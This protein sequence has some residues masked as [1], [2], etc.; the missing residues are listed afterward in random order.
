MARVK[1]S[2]LWLAIRSSDCT[3]SQAGQDALVGGLVGGALPVGLAAAKGVVSPFLS[4]IIAQ[5]NPEGYARRQ[6]AQ[7]IA[8]S[9]QTPNDIG[10]ALQ[11]AQLEGQGNFTVADALGN[12][13][14]RMLSSVARAPGEGRTNVVNT[15]ENRQ[16]G[17]G[18]RVAN[19]LSES[20][21]APETAAQTERRLTQA[22]DEA[23][24]E[25]YGA[26]R[27]DANPVD[28]VDTIN[29]VDNIIGSQPGQQFADAKRHRR[30]PLAWLPGTEAR[31]NPDDFSAVQ[32]IR[33]DM[34]DA[35]QS[36]AQN[37][38]GNRAISA[39]F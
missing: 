20:F 18:R 11:Q 15:L 27:D 21:E 38:Y 6:V 30:E 17:Q 22:R 29:H 37:G 1:I 10:S 13:G 9:G 2:T 12:L 16:A 24:D 35:A 32:R 28:V 36:A 19:A 25:E 33:V 7:A 5:V 39:A 4:N 23:A 8:E 31:V 3:F 14:Q 34:A 26:V